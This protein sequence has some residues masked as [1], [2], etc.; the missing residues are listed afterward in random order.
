MNKKRTFRFVMGYFNKACK[1]LYISK[2][3]FFLKC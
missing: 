3:Y 1:I 2:L